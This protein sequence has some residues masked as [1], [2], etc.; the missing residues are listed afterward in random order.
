MSSSVERKVD[1]ELFSKMVSEARRM[2][3]NDN[4]RPTMDSCITK[5]IENN[6]KDLLKLHLTEDE[7]GI[8]KFQLAYAMR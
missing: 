8:L 1:S 2:Y 3:I 4:S 5:T 6:A 7:M